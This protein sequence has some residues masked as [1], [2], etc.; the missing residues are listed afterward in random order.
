[1]TIIVFIRNT[2]I[3]ETKLYRKLSKTPLNFYKLLKNRKLEKKAIFMKKSFHS[4]EMGVFCLGDCD[5]R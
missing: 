1:M 4:S 3:H 2:H 5:K